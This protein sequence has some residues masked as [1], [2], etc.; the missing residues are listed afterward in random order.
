MRFLMWLMV[1]CTGAFGANSGWANPQNEASAGPPTNALSTVFSP[2]NGGLTASRVAEMAVENAP[3]VEQRR[4]ELAAE[5]ATADETLAMYL[6][7]LTVT[8]STARV[9]QAEMDFLGGGVLVGAEN[10]GPLLVAPCPGGVGNCVVDSE[11]AFVGGVSMDPIEIPLQQSRLTAHLTVP[12]RDYALK[13]KPARSGA[14]ARTHEKLLSREAEKIEVALQGRLAFYD[15]VGAQAQ[16]AMNQ[17]SRSRLVELRADAELAREAGLMTQADVMRIDTQ[18]VLSDATILRAA[19]MVQLTAR[20]LVTLTGI[21]TDELILGEDLFLLPERTVTASELAERVEAAH[22]SRIEV[23]QLAL[24][25]QSLIEGRK[26]ARASMLPRL[27]GFAEAT[28]ANPN[29]VYFPLED[30]WR[31][32]WMVGLQ[33]TGSLSQTLVTRSHAKQA[34]AHLWSLRTQSEGLM[35]GIELEVRST[36]T[37][38]E[39]AHETV[40]LTADALDTTQGIYDQQVLR[41]RG[42]EI[43]A[44]DILDS[45]LELLSAVRHLHSH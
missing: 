21:S 40:A 2:Q 38:L 15:W 4:A 35:R 26:L 29:Q 16:L 27:D 25:E 44:T 45:D 13:I 22:Q 20:Q 17:A 34:D 12:L 42:G 6:P 33:L 24:M 39:R 3:S 43:S 37:E 8:A 28:V 32:N 11:G 10:A 5:L 18:I 7:S 23:R 41:F 1:V 19:A 14:V 31:G 9:S 36:W 30:E